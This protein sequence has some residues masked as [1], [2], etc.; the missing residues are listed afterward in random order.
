MKFGLNNLPFLGND[1]TGTRGTTEGSGGDLAFGMCAGLYLFREGE[2]EG[3]FQIGSTSLSTGYVTHSCLCPRGDLWKCDSGQSVF[4]CGPRQRPL[5]L[6]C[7]SL[8]LR[9]TVGP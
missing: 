5:E 4:H 3:S 7:V 6:T 1:E 9:V 8:R 2:G